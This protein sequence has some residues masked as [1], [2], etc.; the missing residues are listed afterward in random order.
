VNVLVCTDGSDDAVEAARRGLALL[1][2]VDTLT[3]LCAVEAPPLATAGFESGFAGGISSPEEVD[4]AW[5]DVRVR[6][7]EAIER[8]LQALSTIAVVERRVEVGSAGAVICDLA[9]DLGADVVVIGSRGHGALRRALLGSVSTH[10][11]NNAPCPV[12]VVR[13]GVDA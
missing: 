9:G 11:V 10:V 6:A 4:R 12:V 2:T 13:A 5:E 8:T 1:G 3:V 7:D